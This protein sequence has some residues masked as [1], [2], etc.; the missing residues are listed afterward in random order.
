MY[1]QA[2]GATIEILSLGGRKFEKSLTLSGAKESQ[3]KS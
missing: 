2:A 1:N 3:S